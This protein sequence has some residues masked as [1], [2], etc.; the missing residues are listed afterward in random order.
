MSQTDLV[1]LVLGGVI[2]AG[3]VRAAARKIDMRLALLTAAILLGA[4]SHNVPRVIAIFFH[5]FADEKYVVPIC[6]AMGFAHVVGRTGCD[7]HL[8]EAL[9]GPIKRVRFLLIPGGV[10]VGFLVN[11]AVISQAATAAAIGPV[12]IPLMRGAGFSAIAA[13]GTLLLGSSLGGELLNPGAPEYATVV[14]TAA[15]RLGEHEADPQARGSLVARVFP[16]A[17]IQLLISSITLWLTARRRLDI[18]E[19]KNMVNEDASRSAF[20]VNP[21][22]A[23]APLTP[24]L[25]LLATSGIARLIRVP[26]MWLVGST[27]LAGRAGAAAAKRAIEL[28]DARLIG[29][30]MLIG[31]A[32]AAISSLGTRAG[33]ESIGHLGRVFA[34][35]AGEAFYKVITLIVV[36]SCF[37]EG[38]RG[39][40]F[41]Q[42]I[43]KAT[44]FFPAALL[45]TAS[46][47]ASAFAF[48]S[49]SGYA[50]TQGLFPIFATAVGDGAPLDRLAAVTSLSAAAGRTISPVAAVVILSARLSDADERDL[51]RRVSIPL[52]VATATVV[53]IA[54]ILQQ[55]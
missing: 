29:V 24:L 50:A 36:A 11:G 45:P 35:G 32:V 51:I 19:D 18:D 44:H 46:I 13:G 14:D 37:A 25:I 39:I 7:R 2:V 28:Y 6:C 33:R 23:I 38:I 53:V 26:R 10:A 49:G 9:L 42:L 48:L 5:T 41:D 12:L 21:L 30:A 43:M 15:A 17:I 55:T 27:D 16:F 22:K 4:I 8:V 47:F 1:R 34:E 20:T 3:A 54:S 52:L 31:V 40:G